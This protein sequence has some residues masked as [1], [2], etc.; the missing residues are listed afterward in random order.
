[1]PG[2]LKILLFLV[3]CL[4]THFSWANDEQ[5]YDRLYDWITNPIPFEPIETGTHL[6]LKDRSSH[7][8]A[9]IPPHLLYM[10][11][12]RKNSTYY[13]L[14]LLKPLQMDLQSLMQEG[15]QIFQFPGSSHQ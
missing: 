3:F 5:S 8:E 6:G 7:L 14:P 11:R 9:L 1:M 12:H 2:V 15:G 4:F 10:G 13:S